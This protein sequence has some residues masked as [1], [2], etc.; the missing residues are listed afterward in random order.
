MKKLFLASTALLLVSFAVHASSH[1]A[2]KAVK[3]PAIPAVVCEADTNKYVESINTTVVSIIVDEN[4]DDAKKT[5]LLSDMFRQHVNIE[6]LG[7]FVLGK[8][9]R[10]LKPEQQTQYLQAYEHYRRRCEPD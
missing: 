8:H 5:A 2:E 6:W 3:N 10:D 9:W 1:A 4:N 7:R